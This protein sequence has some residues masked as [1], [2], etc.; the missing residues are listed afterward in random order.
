[1]S[2]PNEALQKLLQEIEAKAS[3]SQQQLGIVKAQ[4]VAKNRESRMLQLT[5][6][7]VVSLPETTNVYEGVGK[8]FVFSPPADVK[9]RL[10]SETAAL[11]KE[12]VNLE[13]KLHYLDTTYKN[14]QQGIEQL[15]RSGGG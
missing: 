3:F 9:E 10:A 11:E 14:S 15:L 8:M 5:T 7:E 6:S 13:K 12:M 2:I 4:I 1:M